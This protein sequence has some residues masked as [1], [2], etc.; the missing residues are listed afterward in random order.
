MLFFFL[1]LIIQEFLAAYCLLHKEED[2]QLEWLSRAFSDEKCILFLKFFCG[3]DKFKSHSART[4]YSSKPIN[5]TFV[6]ECI[7]EAQNDAMCKDASKQC[8]KCVLFKR[9]MA[10]YQGMVYAYVMV[11]SE[12]TWDICWNE[13]EFE[14]TSL[15]YFSQYTKESPK[16]IKKMVIKRPILITESG[17]QVLA[18]IISVQRTLKELSFVDIDFQSDCLAKLLLQIMHHPSITILCIRDSIVL[19]QVAES[20]AIVIN[21]MKTLR[22]LD[23][24]GSK[25]SEDTCTIFKSLSSTVKGLRLNWHK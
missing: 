15:Q 18:G 8:E 2:K 17:I 11:K 1:H 12:A 21:Q 10:P 5:S 24:A 6:F 9:R 7:Y 16:L 20:L 3:L 25:F 23:L 13:F 19:L 14:G 4:I 22:C